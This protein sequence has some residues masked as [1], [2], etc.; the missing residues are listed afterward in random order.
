MAPVQ[1]PED[2]D[3]QLKRYLKTLP[4][5][6]RRAYLASLRGQ[7]PARQQAIPQGF[8]MNDHGYSQALGAYMYANA[9]HGMQGNYL[10]GMANTA[11]GAIA[12]EN[13]RRVALAR[14]QR[15]MQH[16]QELER[17]RQ[18]GRQSPARQSPED[19]IRYLRFLSAMEDKKRGLPTHR[20]LVDGVWREPWELE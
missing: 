4:L 5:N 3:E 9:M 14:E 8:N 10:Q 17:I 7:E 13:D 19:S 2:P 20:I 18:E 15:R 16:E 12:K 1:K 11:M 6:E